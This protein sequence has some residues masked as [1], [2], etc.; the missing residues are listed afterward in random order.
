MRRVFNFINEPRGDVLR[1]L[2]GAVAALSTSSIL[3]I[4]DE[5]GLSD[6]AMSLLSALEPHLVERQRSSSWPGTSLLDEKAT[7]IRFLHS[8]VLDQ[9]LSAAEGL[10]EWQQPSLPEDLAFLRDDGT[11]LLASISHEQDAFLEVSDDEY[12]ALV[13]QVPE[14]SQL[15]ALQEE[16]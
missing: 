12:Q 8:A 13:Q 7:V 11:A 1:R 10:Y 15:T 6:T 9:L 5:L 4:R 2:M 3:V 14:L 16:E